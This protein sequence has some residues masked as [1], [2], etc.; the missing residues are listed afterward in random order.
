VPDFSD[1]LE[2]D[3]ATIE[4]SLAGPRRPQDRVALDDVKA[5]FVAALPDMSSSK[6]T[7]PRNVAVPGKPYALED[8]AILLAAITS[9]TNTSNPRLM[10]A[11]GLVARKAR[12]A[13]L[14]VPAWV[15]TS[16]SP[17]SLAVADYLEQTG[18][19]KDLDA[20]GF[21]ITGFGCMTCCG[22]SGALDDDIIR[23]TREQELVGAAVLSGNRNFENR[24]HPA[25]RAAYLCSPPLVVAYALAGSVL[26]D[27]RA[28]VGTAPDG[29]PVSLADL[30]PDDEEIDAVV[31]SIGRPLFEKRFRKVFDG[32]AQWHE[33]DT[34]ESILFDWDAESTY[35]RRPPY[36][37]G[38][39]GETPRL[40]DL[41]GA[42]ALVILGDSIT[43]D[44]IS[45][46]GSIEENTI[47]GAYLAERGVA[48]RDFNQYGTRRGNHEVMMRGVF[49]NPRLKNEILA[50]EG[51]QGNA[52]RVQPRG[53]V[54][55][56]YD[57]AK[58]YA[59][60]NTPLVVIAGKEYGTGSSR[61]WAAKGPQLIGVRAI[62][63]ESFERIHRIN[64]IGAGVLPLQFA[65]G[66]TRNTIAL[67]G[68]ELFDIVGLRSIDGLRERVQLRVHRADGRIDSVPLICRVET[69]AELEHLHHG[70]LLRH[71]LRDMLAEHA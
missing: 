51:I 54:M 21:Q 59:R 71:V 31:R 48:P 28:Q 57:A 44:H 60:E 47:G 22:N 9:C 35:I 49:S 23:L 43:T 24:V 34:R 68:S 12:R 52:T 66:V 53:D 46:V 26:D 42:R 7:T 1:T 20:L 25:V 4:T 62:I 17:G 3:L 10:I 63:A 18:L 55:S 8:G 5:S 19:Q 11:A 6:A 64:L 70:G 33:L 41:C 67:D 69:R 39:A 40:Q 61:D 2:I 16:L 13:G 38:M 56:I 65:D 50:A 36:F 14:T 45:P 37:D 30:W 32:P 58:V 15:K 29:T 27:L